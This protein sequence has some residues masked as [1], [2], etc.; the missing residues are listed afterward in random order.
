MIIIDQTKLLQLEILKEQG[1]QMAQQKAQISAQLQEIELSKNTLNDIK[2]AKENTKIMIPLGAGMYFKGK[3]TSTDSI[4]TLSEG[5]V[6]VIKTPKEADEL[7]D[8]RAG[9][10][11]ELDA[12]ID[13]ELEKIDKESAKILK[14]LEAA[15]AKESSK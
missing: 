5:G 6:A 13:A 1:Q 11:K 15:H 14:E 9:S 10:M 12:R 8:E 2:N 4:I 3:L 7:L